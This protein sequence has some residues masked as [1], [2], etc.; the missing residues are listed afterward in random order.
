VDGAWVS[1]RSPTLPGLIPGLPG[2]TLANEMIPTL[3]TAGGLQ[4]T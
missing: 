4:T 3:S 2:T 1:K